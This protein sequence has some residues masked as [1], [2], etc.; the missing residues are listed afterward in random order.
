MHK[1]NKEKLVKSIERFDKAGG[2]SSVT[3]ADPF[4]VP[5][6]RKQ[7][8]DLLIQS[9]VYTGIDNVEKAVQAIKHGYTT[10]CLEPSIN[11]NA[12]ELKKIMKLKVRYPAVDVK[13]LANHLCYSSCMYYVRHS[14][15][16]IQLQE[17]CNGCVGEDIVHETC[18]YG[19]RGPKE[20]ITRTII[21]PDD[22]K[23]YEDLADVLK[24]AFR[25]DPTRELKPR[26]EAYF[27]GKFEGDLFELL[28]TNN[29]ENMS[30]DNT[31]IPED[32]FHKVSECDKDCEFCDY[33]G[34]VAGKAV[35]TI[36]NLILELNSVCNSNC[37]Y[38]YLED[39]TGRGEGTIPFFMQKLEEYAG[40]GVQNVDFTGGEPTLYKNVLVLIK[41]AKDLGYTNRSLVTNG[42]MFSIRKYAEKFVSAGINRVVVTLDGPE[43]GIAE[44]LTQSP[45]SFDQTIKGLKNAKDRKKK[46]EKHKGKA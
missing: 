14:A 34:D 21:R 25:N 29:K 41:H 43:S 3:V 37:T 22:V 26:L 2:I 16:P 11:R 28:G 1:E 6:I 12:K 9:S 18:H 24:I 13:L 42:R 4:A 19:K 40:T 5:F 46:A 20:E 15:L 33:C 36:N 30:C 23:H 44:G 7:F 31:K 39:K 32:F 10:L 38:C 35:S 45:G 17:D 27:K 8:P